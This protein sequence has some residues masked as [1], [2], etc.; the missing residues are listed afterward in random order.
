[1]AEA[2]K[3]GDLFNAKMVIAS[4]VEPEKQRSSVQLKLL[5]LEFTLGKKESKFRRQRMELGNTKDRSL[6]V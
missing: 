4:T 5:P 3:N 1:M 2:G 6:S